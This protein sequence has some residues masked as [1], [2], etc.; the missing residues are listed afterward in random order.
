MSRLS[1]RAAVTA[2]MREKGRWPLV[3]RLRWLRVGQYVVNVVVVAINGYLVSVL[4]AASAGDAVGVTVAMA[5]AALGF[6]L[7]ALQQWLGTR[8]AGYR[9]RS[10]LAVFVLFDLVCTLLQLPLVAVLATAGLPANCHGITS[11]SDPDVFGPSGRGL[12][13]RY[14]A[15][16]NA[17]FWL[18]MILTLSYTYTISLIVRQIAAVNREA[19]LLRQEQKDNESN[20]RIAA[21]M[22]AHRAPP[23][24][25][26]RR[27]PHPVETVDL[28]AEPVRPAPPRDP[29]AVAV[30]PPPA[31]P[32]E[33]PP[34][35][36]SVEPRR[37]LAA[38]LGKN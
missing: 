35:Y 14:C 21:I 17:T 29:D 23:R 28:G 34:P 9:R 6:V 18:S 30:P 33:Q 32:E 31:A 7:T 26:S 16:P 19:K 27:R 5:V 2:V 15:V 11:G 8:L 38:S 25:W 22:A 1:V 37:H 3:R 24:T 20:E 4:A 13:P 12:T 10:C 36:I